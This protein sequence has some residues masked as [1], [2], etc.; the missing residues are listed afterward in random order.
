IWSGKRLLQEIGVQ[1]DR[2]YLLDNDFDSFYIMFVDQR[3]I[4]VKSPQIKDFT[5]SEHKLSTPELVYKKQG[6]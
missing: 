6:V 3:I 4:M 2:L 5:F 1:E